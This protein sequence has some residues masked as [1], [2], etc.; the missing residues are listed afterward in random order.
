MAFSTRES[1]EF[2]VHT[3]EQQFHQNKQVNHARLKEAKRWV[4]QN[5]NVHE[6]RTLLKNIESLLAGYKLPIPVSDSF[7]I[8]RSYRRPSDPGVITENCAD[9]SFIHGD[10]SVFAKA[11]YETREIMKS[12]NLEKL[13]WTSYIRTPTVLMDGFFVLSLDVGLDHVGRPSNFDRYMFSFQHDD[14]ISSVLALVDEFHTTFCPRTANVQP[15]QQNLDWSGALLDGGKAVYNGFDDFKRAI[16]LLFEKYRSLPSAHWASKPVHLVYNPDVGVAFEVPPASHALNELIEFE[17]I[18]GYSFSNYQSINAAYACMTKLNWLAA[19]RQAE[20]I[21]SIVLE[22]LHW[23]MDNTMIGYVSK[24]IEH[25]DVDKLDVLFHSLWFKSQHVN[26]KNSDNPPPFKSLVKSS[27]TKEILFSVLEAMGPSSCGSATLSY[28]REHIE[29][30]TNDDH[31]LIAAFKS[32]NKDAK[33]ELAVLHDRINWQQ[34]FE[35]YISEQ[36]NKNQQLQDLRNDLVPKNDLI[37]NYGE[38]RQARD[39]ALNANKETSTKIDELNDELKVLKKAR[40][41]IRDLKQVSKYIRQRY[42][43]IFL[44]HKSPSRLLRVRKEPV[45]TSLERDAKLRVALIDTMNEECEEMESKIKKEKKAHEKNLNDIQKFDE[46][47]N[48]L[49]SISESKYNQH[50]QSLDVTGISH[51]IVVLEGQLKRLIQQIERH[52]TL[53]PIK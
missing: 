17:R 41:E 18:R 46:R 12:I 11:M 37:K 1:V 50:P 5:L 3:Q 8:K 31:Q 52:M 51:Q 48:H 21:Q 4:E 53:E 24:N 44:N 40:H 27:M 25:F 29:I 38:A 49:V 34:K 47:L 39:G 28:L 33:K 19:L 35:T 42:K 26:S 13:G 20:S 36:K 16:P 2:Y 7:V 9:N 10:D 23:P 45:E 15:A 43:H 6:C 32:W 14:D 30:K 22:I